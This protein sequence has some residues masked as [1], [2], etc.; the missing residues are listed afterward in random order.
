MDEQKTYFQKII[1]LNLLQ[2]EKNK[3]KEEKKIGSGSFGKVML[4]KYISTELAVKK[5]KNL[6]FKD[7]YK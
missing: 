4:S 5:L 6:N 3:I 7:F 1:N 2:L